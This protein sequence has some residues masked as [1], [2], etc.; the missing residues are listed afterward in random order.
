MVTTQQPPST[1]EAT[2]S[3]QRLKVLISAYTCEPGKGSEPGVGWNV[4]Q[5]VSR[6]HE[7]WV[8]TRADRREKIDPELAKNPLPNVHFIYYELPWILRFYRK[9][10]RLQSLHY[11][12]WQYGAALAARRAHRQH[13]FDLAQHVTYVRYWNPS[14]I[15][16]LPIPFIW[17]PV[18]GG[19][20][21]PRSFYKTLSQRGRFFEFLRDLARDVAHFDPAVHLT[22][23]RAHIGL[24]T[25]RESEAKMRS[26]GCKNIE[27]VSETSLPVDER[28]KL[29]ALPAR[30][31]TPFRLVSLGRLLDWKGFHLG[32]MAFAQ[33]LKTHPDAEYWVIGKGPQQAYLE[34]LV[35]ELGISH[36]VK[37]WGALPRAQTLEKLSECDVLV[38][39]SLHDSGGWVC[40]EAMASG[41]PVIC[42][43]LGGPGVQVTDETGFRVR[44]G[45]PEQA[46]ADMA[47]VMERLA[48]DP[49]L[50][51]R[52][53]AA[54]KQR[55]E[56]AFDWN[57]KGE[58]LNALYQR[59]MASRKARA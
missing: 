39:P 31:T 44:A 21:A 33:F 25:T 27:I 46:I 59:I 17:G 10:T 38:H 34:S 30:S 19:E 20:S 47:Q 28:Q 54:G 13:K 22:A 16:L 1:T 4:V 2:D 3:G 11:Y 29:N 58:Q 35:K 14:L 7:T 53:G 12:L 41:R 43:D 32:L 6:F 24:A 50:R 26:L 18:G 42:L 37:I 9:G 8:I 45:T 56:T 5:Q 40:L 49:D 52:M 51:Q 55:V 23:R 48:N 57:A 36:R 15:S